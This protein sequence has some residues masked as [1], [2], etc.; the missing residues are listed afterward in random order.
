MEHGGSVGEN[1]LL[2]N[3]EAEY[4]ELEGVDM[5]PTAPD[6]DLA[7]LAGLLGEAK[8]TE[9]VSAMDAFPVV[10]E[11]AGMATLTTDGEVNGS[12]GVDQVPAVVTDGEFIFSAEAVG[13]I[14]LDALKSAHEEARRVAASS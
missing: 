9:L 13:V 5:A 1:S 8:W 12:A 7:A 11:V 3:P 4:E 2:A 6:T 14:G 10:A